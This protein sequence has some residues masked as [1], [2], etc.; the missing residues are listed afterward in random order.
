MPLNIILQIKKERRKLT[1][2]GAFETVITFYRET[3]EANEDAL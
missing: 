3:E 2:K 1:N